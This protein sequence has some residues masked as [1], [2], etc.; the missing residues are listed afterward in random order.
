MPQF[1]LPLG[2]PPGPA[3]FAS[4]DAFTQGYVEALFFTDA[5][6]P[7][8]GDLQDATFAEL[9][10]DALRTIEHQCTA[11]QVNNAKLLSRAYDRDDY[12]EVQAGR[13]F[14]FT[15]NRHGAGFWDRTQL[16][17]GKLGDRLSEACKLHH[18]C[19][20]YRGGDGQV[21]MG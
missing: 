8:D 6:D 15:R 11:F 21:H 10:P 13:D 20:V 7:D 18:E 5:S 17:A 16:A 14:W 19:Y 12:S 4:L 3:T 9:A 1:I 2:D